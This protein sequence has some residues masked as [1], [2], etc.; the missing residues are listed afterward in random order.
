MTTIWT[1]AGPRPNSDE[2]PAVHV[3]PARVDDDTLG[4]LYETGNPAA[5]AE[6]YMGKLVLDCVNNSSSIKAL[7]NEVRRLREALAKTKEV[8]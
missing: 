3:A 1:G 4:F 2:I 6:Q 5:Y 7:Q 8:K